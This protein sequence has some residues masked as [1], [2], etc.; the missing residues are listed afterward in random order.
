MFVISITILSQFNVE[1]LFVGFYV[2][3]CLNIIH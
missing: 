2:D 1:M 3:Q